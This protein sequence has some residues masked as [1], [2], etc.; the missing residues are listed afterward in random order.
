MLELETET[1]ME[2]RL[3]FRKDGGASMD[4][5]LVLAEKLSFMR[6]WLESK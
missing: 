3:P 4:K 6:R 5:P 1:L 2:A